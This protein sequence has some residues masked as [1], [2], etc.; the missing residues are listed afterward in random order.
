MFGKKESEFHLHDDWKF[1]G[2]ENFITK[3]HLPD[4]LRT[5]LGTLL[6]GMCDLDV[7][8]ISERARGFI[9]DDERAWKNRQ[10][11][12]QWDDFNKIQFMS[13]G[14]IERYAEEYN[15]L[16]PYLENTGEFPLPGKGALMHTVHWDL[17]YEYSKHPKGLTFDKFFLKYEIN[18]LFWFTLIWGWDAGIKDKGTWLVLQRSPYW[19]KLYSRLF[20][21]PGQ[22]TEFSVC[23]RGELLRNWQ[24][25]HAKQA[26]DAK[27]IPLTYEQKCAIWL[28]NEQEW[29]T[30]GL[31][32]KRVEW[33]KYDFPSCNDGI[34][35]KNMYEEPQADEDPDYWKFTSDFA[36]ELAAVRTEKFKP[37]EY[38]DADYDKYLDESAKKDLERYTKDSKQYWDARQN[39]I[40]IALVFKKSAGELLLTRNWPLDMKYSPNS[41]KWHTVGYAWVHM[42]N[43]MILAYKH[44]LDIKPDFKESLDRGYMHCYMVEY[45]ANGAARTHP[46]KCA[47][48]GPMEKMEAELAFWKRWYMTEEKQYHHIDANTDVDPKGQTSWDM[49][50]DD[51]ANEIHDEEDKRVVNDVNQNVDFDYG[52]KDLELEVH[53][54]WMKIGLIV[55]AIGL[56]IFLLVRGKSRGNLSNA[57]Y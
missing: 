26:E 11:A 43:Q 2:N 1:I 3:Q 30:T 23:E 41:F 42:W 17:S 57:Y 25:Y 8:T 7:R 53:K 20:V 14:A 34:A 51:A 31:G 10:D 49:N 55:G 5:N 16:P 18:N 15:A 38:Y 36:K 28:K 46:F 50:N 39:I 6:D 37:V 47:T 19:A 13:P 24:A 54:D 29:Y 9:H 48:S 56:M 40:R 27:K 4:T 12:W 33:A 35:P 22:K 21:E 44:W 52:S 32:N 45:N